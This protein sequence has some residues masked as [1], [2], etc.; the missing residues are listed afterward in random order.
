MMDGI[1]ANV[2]LLAKEHLAGAPTTPAPPPRAGGLTP[3]GVPQPRPD[4][5]GPRRRPRGY[6][7]SGAAE[8]IVNRV[9][10]G[11]ADE[12]RAESRVQLLNHVAGLEA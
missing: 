5:C 8:A 6:M 9:A 1:H 7:P 2:L 11:A 4:R 10:T 3:P 12:Q